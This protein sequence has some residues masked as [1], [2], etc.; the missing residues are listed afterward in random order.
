M[1]SAV[2]LIL[3]VLIAFCGSA[4]VGISSDN[5]TPDPSAGLEV[6]FT[7]KGFL[8]PRMTAT[9]IALISQPADGLIVYCTTDNKLYTF[10]GPTGQWKEIA[11]GAAAISPVA[12][13]GLNFSVSHT[14]GAVA[15]VT[16]TV[17]YGTVNNV[18]GETT[19]CWLTRN[20]GASQQATSPG[21]D[22]E[23]GAGWYWQ[24]NRLRGFKHDGVTLTPS[25]T[26]TTI[27]ENSDWLPGNDP[28][29]AELG[30]AWR[31]PT[32]AEWFNVDNAGGWINFIGPW[33]SV[34]KMHC[35]GYL[36][37]VNG[38]LTSRGI[39]AYYWANS[40]SGNSTAWS[41][42]FGPDY[43]GTFN[44]NGKA[45]AFPLRCLRVE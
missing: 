3:F 17:V 35:A 45:F 11:F 29:S 12:S 10:H 20:L 28:C 42:N 27:S 4:Q 38:S 1:K 31:I 13:C 2:I 23:A 30:T 34:L 24:F 8:P 9:Q 36:N 44:N 26:V 21:D 5:S 18:P 33:S 19:K 40:Q 32:H 43:A 6:K 15:P 41:L 7:N 16:K 37:D 25:W 22:S 39:T 14:A